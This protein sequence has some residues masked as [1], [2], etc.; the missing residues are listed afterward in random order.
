MFYSFSVHQ[1][2]RHNAKMVILS[3]KINSMRE[4]IRAESFVI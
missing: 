1:R 3:I 2:E 4:H